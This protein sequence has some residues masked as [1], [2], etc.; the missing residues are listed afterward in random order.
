MYKRKKI[1]YKNKYDH[2]YQVDA[3]L[4]FNFYHI[5]EFIENGD[6][7]FAIEPG[8]SLDVINSII[9]ENRNIIGKNSPLI[10]SDILSTEEDERNKDLY[11]INSKPSI[12]Q[13]AKYFDNKLYILIASRPEV[14]IR[15]E[16]YHFIYKFSGSIPT[17]NF[18]ND[19][20]RIVHYN[21]YNTILY[22]ISEF[23][24]HT[25]IHQLHFIISNLRLTKS[26][27]KY[28]NGCRINNTI[29]THADIYVSNTNDAIIHYLNTGEIRNF[30]VFTN[31]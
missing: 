25:N 21:F 23:N 10:Y 16:S 26:K 12:E 6:K 13:F 8:Y 31:K 1:Q 29:S 30:S 11:I 9:N 22:Y 24:Y 27:L 19:I 18:I 7:D 17:S 28:L 5:N 4:P 14:H 20:A 3:N 15:F 2:G